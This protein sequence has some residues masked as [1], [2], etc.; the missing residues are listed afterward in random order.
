MQSESEHASL[1]RDLRILLSETLQR[2]IE[3]LRAGLREELQQGLERAFLEGEL[4]TPHRPTDSDSP[5]KP[6][7]EWTQRHMRTWHW[8][9]ADDDDVELPKAAPEQTKKEGVLSRVMKKKATWC[10]GVD[11]ESDHHSE[12]HHVKETDTTK[13]N[14]PSQGWCSPQ[15]APRGD[16]VSP[17]TPVMPMEPS[18]GPLDRQTTESASVEVP[19]GVPEPE[20]DDI[21]APMSPC[22]NLA[23]HELVDKSFVEEV[24]REEPQEIRNS[25]T[26]HSFIYVTR[27]KLRPSQSHPSLALKRSRLVHSVVLS[28]KFDSFMCFFIL[29]NSVVLGAQTDF[30]ARYPDDD[31]P[32]I[33]FHLEIAFCFI[34]AMELF[35][36]LYV[37]RYSFFYKS[38]WQWNVF[39]CVLICLQ[40]TE[41][42]VLA[43]VPK[44]DERDGNAFEGVNDFSAARVARLLRLIR[45]LRVARVLQGISELRIL[46]VSILNSF[47]SLF[48]SVVLVLLLVY[49]VSLYLTQVVTDHRQAV[50]DDS[51]Q[52]SVDL[53]RNFGTLAQTMLSMFAAITSGID[54]A[55]LCD[56][57]KDEISPVLA[58]FF[59]AYIAF[60]LLAILNMVTGVFVESV[61]SSQRIDRDHFILSNTRELFMGLEGG[62]SATMDWEMFKSKVEAPQMQSFF[63]F[64]DVDPSDAKG[65]FR[66]LDIDGSGEVSAEEFLNGAVRL[67]GTAKALDVALLIQ[68]VRQLGKDW[69]RRAH[70]GMV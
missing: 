43:L 14:K 63:K 40:V 4:Q 42:V 57:L 34:F 12:G 45:V 10:R 61:L 37:H 38:G 51:S 46:V 67:R 9:D 44:D 66:L 33:L 59:S 7:H 22:P 32:R 53:R 6:Q 62:L 50:G 52:A 54:W 49:T 47:K 31:P 58:V 3:D 25:I 13:P 29:L 19:G 35:I 18:P 36:R 15:G 27:P 69:H 1:R 21:V 56:P 28:P 70:R 20:D 60:S 41:Q 55:Q 26:Q 17:L 11:T 68:E 65:L 16:Q 30:R 48:F 5:E 2:G 24:D 23:H 8:R 64:L 39:D